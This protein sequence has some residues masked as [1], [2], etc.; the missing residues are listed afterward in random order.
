MIERV[1]NFFRGVDV[2]ERQ[3]A[4]IV[5]REINGLEEYDICEVVL[6]SDGTIDR[7]KLSETTAIAGLDTYRIENTFFPKTHAIP[8]VE[9]DDLETVF[10]TLKSDTDKGGSDD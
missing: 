4:A 7:K 10:E 1:K 9:D 5:R 3:R 6:Y 8:V 2:V